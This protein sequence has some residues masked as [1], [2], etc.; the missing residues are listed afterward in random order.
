MASGAA[1]SV[2]GAASDATGL[3]L[4]HALDDRLAVYGYETNTGVKLVAVV[5]M[6][7][8]RGGSGGGVAPGSGAGSAA[9]GG[10]GALGG[11]VVGLRDAELKPVRSPALPFPF[12][13][14][15]P[16]GPPALRRWSSL[17]TA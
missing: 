6:R 4:L 16:V 3:L 1:S 7:G 8:R 9:A 2:G 5:D 10:R 14:P 11:G 15:F 17:L 13:F 12:P